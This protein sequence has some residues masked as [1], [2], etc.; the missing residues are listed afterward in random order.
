MLF[1]LDL[2]YLAE[3]LIMNILLQWPACYAQSTM[4]GVKIGHRPAASSIIILLV[5]LGGLV[6]ACMPLGPRFMD[7][8]MTLDDG[9]LRVIKMR[10]MIFFRR[11]V[12]PSVPC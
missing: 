5:A 10:S 9:L 4:E 12:K 3:K 2:S 8:N 7:S 11:E 1:C 6:V